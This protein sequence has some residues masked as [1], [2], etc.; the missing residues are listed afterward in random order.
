MNQ[1][2]TY[3][4][5]NILKWILDP[6]LTLLAT[7]KWYQLKGILV[8]EKKKVKIEVQILDSHENRTNKSTLI[9]MLWCHGK[10]EWM[11]LELDDLTVRFEQYEPQ[12]SFL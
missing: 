1:S 2:F 3:H 12:F 7:F 5:W 6:A 11:N 10:S 4:L 8:A 9:E